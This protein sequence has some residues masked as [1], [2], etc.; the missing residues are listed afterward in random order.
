MTNENAK[1]IY[2]VLKEYGLTIE[3]IDSDNN[4]IYISVPKS[5]DMKTISGCDVAN[6][7][8]AKKFK[9]MFKATRYTINY[10]VRNEH[11][12]AAMAHDAKNFAEDIAFNF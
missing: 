5:S 1:A 7:Y 8:L 12:T 9:D 3:K 10:K 2:I 4:A 11:W 6:L